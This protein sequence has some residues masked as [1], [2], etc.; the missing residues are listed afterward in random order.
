MSALDELRGLTDE[1]AS[2]LTRGKKD[3]ADEVRSS[4]RS[5]RAEVIALAETLERQA[6]GHVANGQD[7]LAGRALIEARALRAGVAALTPVETRDDTDTK[8]APRGRKTS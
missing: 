8:S 1:M 3:R 7:I 4:L 2:V 5:K 6:E